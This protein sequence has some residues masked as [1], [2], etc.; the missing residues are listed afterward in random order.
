VYLIIIKVL[1]LRFGQQMI[2]IFKEVIILANS[3]FFFF[4][5]KKRNQK[6]NRNPSNK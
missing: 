1:R 6:K 5:K 2:F 3:V 4:K